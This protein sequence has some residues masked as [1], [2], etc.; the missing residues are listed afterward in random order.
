MSLFFSRSVF[1]TTTGT[2]V[3]NPRQQVTS[4]TSWIDGSQVYGSDAETAAS[5]REF[6]GGRMLISE[7]GMMPQDDHGFFMGGDIRA[8]ENSELTA[9]QTLWVREHNYRA[10]RIA[11]KD[12]KLNHEDV[13]QQ[14]RAIV[15]AEIQSI[16]FNEFLP[17]LLGKNA[18]SR[19]R[20]PRPIQLHAIR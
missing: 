10:D 6:S 1:D 13:Y 16:T 5:L 18:I 11:A 19:Y 15:G 3:D 2:S 12:P 4:I 20:F 17:A 7:D 9:M 8:N 14:A